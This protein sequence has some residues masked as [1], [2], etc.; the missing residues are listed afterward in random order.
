MEG[1]IILALT[2]AGAFLKENPTFLRFARCALYIPRNAAAHLARGL[3]LPPLDPPGSNKIY[4]FPSPASE[5][6]PRNA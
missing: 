5:S 6:G 4:A 2:F 3:S 1:T